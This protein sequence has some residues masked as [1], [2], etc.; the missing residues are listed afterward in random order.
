MPEF[1]NPLLRRWELG[2]TLR[3][4]REERSMTIADVTVAMK[5]RYGSSFSTAK[6]SRIETAKRGVIP[7]DV[8]DLCVLYGVPDRERED[9]IELAKASRAVERVQVGYD[10]RGYLWYVAL[11]QIASQ[12]REFS[13]M[14]IPGLLQTAEYALA[15]ENLT[16]LSPEYYLSELPTEDLPDTA[17][18]R[19]DLRLERQKLLEQG[20][21]LHLHVVIDENAFR[22]KIS[23]PGAMAKQLQHLLEA[24]GQP[25][26]CLQVIPFEVG[27]YPGAE[28]TYWSIVDFPPGDRYPPRTAYV[29]NPAGSRIIDHEADITRLEHA[30][31][32][33][34]R[35]A[36]DPRKSRS[37]IEQ[38][39]TETET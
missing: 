35:L 19:S 14:F 4:L 2:N 13:S 23:P 17:E 5:E 24:S 28:T 3:R 22:R 12:I 20:A 18:G 16:L 36:L 37:L 33:M 38:I 34:T 6:L 11:E 8:H 10:T 7:R 26:I 15:V 9:L 21:G 30:F 32:T 29:E 1:A 25:N 31:K 27:L 39:L